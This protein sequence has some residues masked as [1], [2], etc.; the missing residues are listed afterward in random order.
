MWV[1]L[2]PGQYYDVSFRSIIRNIYQQSGL[3]GVTQEL[4][5]GSIIH[6]GDKACKQEIHLLLKLTQEVQNR[7][8]T[9]VFSYQ[10][11]FYNMYHLI[12]VI[13]RNEQW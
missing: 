6:T 9:Q 7:G 11:I 8:I 1:L 10:V 12:I 13:N 4:I 5:Q 3:A 2:D